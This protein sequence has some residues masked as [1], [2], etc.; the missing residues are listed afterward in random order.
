MAVTVG[1]LV[2]MY[3][4]KN[5]GLGLILDKIDDIGKAAG[6]NAIDIIK[7][8]SELKSWLART[9]YKKSIIDTASNKGLA[10]AFFAYNA[11]SWCKKPK[12][13]FVQIKWFRPPSDYENLSL[14][15]DIN[16]YP[17]DWVK[18]YK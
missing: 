14:K 7:D 1:D 4:R 5:K 16:W 15:E 3:R 17:A 10:Q 18:K 2:C 6:I 11:Q 12:T 13:C 8:M 9:E